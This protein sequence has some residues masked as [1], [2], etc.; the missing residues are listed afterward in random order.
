MVHCGRWVWWRGIAIVI[1]IIIVVSVVTR[2]SLRFFTES[3]DNEEKNGGD[4][5]ALN[6]ALSISSTIAAL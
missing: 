4:E 1:V 2:V 3:T 5:K 6:H